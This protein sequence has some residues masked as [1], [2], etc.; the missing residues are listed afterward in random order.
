MVTEFL[1]T[2]KETK[3]KNRKEKK[4][5]DSFTYPEANGTNKLCMSNV[6]KKHIVFPFQSSANQE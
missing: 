2:K 5:K 6:N 3:R 4:M 1:R